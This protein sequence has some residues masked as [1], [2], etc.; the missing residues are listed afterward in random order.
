MSTERDQDP[1]EASENEHERPRDP[2]V[3]RAAE[4]SVMVLF[5]I[6]V[7]FGIFVVFVLGTCFLM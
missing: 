5:G 7:L 4:S 3:N 6:C 1:K 2:S